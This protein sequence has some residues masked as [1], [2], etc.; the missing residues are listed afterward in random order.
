MLNGSFHSLRHGRVSIAQR[1]PCI[2]PVNAC[3]RAYCR[4]LALIA[5]A[6][7]SALPCR[8]VNWLG[9]LTALLLPGNLESRFSRLQ[10]SSFRET[11]DPLLRALAPLIALYWATPHGEQRPP[12]AGASPEAGAAPVAGAAAATYAAALPYRSPFRLESSLAAGELARTSTTLYVP[13]SPAETLDSLRGELQRYI[14]PASSAETLPPLPPLPPG[15]L[16]GWRSNSQAP[17]AAEP[18]APA[19]NPANA[20]P[21]AAPPENGMPSAAPNSAPARIHTLS[22]AVL[23]LWSD[24][25]EIAACTRLSWMQLASFPVRRAPDRDTGS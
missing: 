13:L 6:A 14:P 8:I 20:A 25:A 12:E 19:A 2:E 7:V 15:I 22:G 3:R 10:A 23:R 21:P 17:A 5:P 11:G 9:D 24:A 1:E 16:I 4:Y 18:S